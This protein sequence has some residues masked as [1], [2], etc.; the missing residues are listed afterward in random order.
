MDKKVNKQCKKV[1]VLHVDA[2][3]YMEL[4]NDWM[5]L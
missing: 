5:A 2:R 1:A 4:L 3:C